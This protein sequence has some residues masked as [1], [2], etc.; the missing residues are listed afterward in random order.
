M[1]INHANH[2]QTHDILFDDGNKFHIKTSH[3]K[4]LPSRIQS[5]KSHIDVLETRG[6]VN[7]LSK[8]EVAELH[9]LSVDLHSLS[10]ANASITWQ[11]SRLLWLREGDANS[12]Y[13]HAI[14]S[15]RRRKNAMSSI[16]VDNNIV[17]GVS[18]VREA[19]FNHFMH[20]FQTQAVHRHQVDNLHFRKLSVVEGVHL[21]CP[22]N[23]EEV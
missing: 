8:K 22:F 20:H 10:K 12:K 17:D 19:V 18:N 7:V 4:N 2:V 9:S 1:K 23:V 21:T 16:V 11:Q 15:G 6:E 14:M 13:F 3:T 5:L